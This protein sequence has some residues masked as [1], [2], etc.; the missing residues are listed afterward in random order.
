[1]SELNGNGTLKLKNRAGSTRG[2]KGV[3]KRLAFPGYTR[4]EDFIETLQCDEIKLNWAYIEPIVIRYKG[5]LRSADEERI[6]LGAKLCVIDFKISLLRVR[7]GEVHS[8]YFESLKNRGIDS[9]SL[10]QA[11]VKVERAHGRWVACGDFND[12]REAALFFAEYEAEENAARVQLC[13]SPKRAE[14]GILAAFQPN[15]VALNSN[16]ESPKQVA[17]STLSKRH[18]KKGEGQE[19]VKAAFTLH[20]E[21]DTG[22]I[23]NLAAISIQ[24]L[25]RKAGVSSSTA[26]AFIDRWFKDHK[27]Y[28]SSA[29][30]DSHHLLLVLRQI[31][32]ENFAMMLY[33][34]D[35]QKFEGRD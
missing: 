35:S 12:L 1:M 16:Q 28:E 13:I 24:S 4:I 3:N 34:T 17:P 14:P 32:G 26:K 5:I 25:S 29:A 31:N 23:G 10:L 15:H 20:H 11:Q 7:V 30:G 18:V 6:R 19:K 33:G 22:S 27:A 2:R 8:F 21:Y 9:S